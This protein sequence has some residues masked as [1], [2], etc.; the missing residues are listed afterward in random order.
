MA[1]MYPSEW[2]DKNGSAA[3]R[4]IW[5]RLRDQTPDDWFAIHSVGLATHDRKPWAEA[6]FVVVAGE[7]VVVL[8]VK[9]GRVTVEGGRWWTN[10]KPLRES[11]FAQAGGAS[12][13]LYG[14]LKDRFPAI[15][16]AIVGWGVV[17]PD[18]TFD[19]E[20]PDIIPAV[21]YD[22]R[23][24]SAPISDYVKRVGAHW[25]SFHRGRDDAFRPLSRAD[26][27]AIVRYLAPTFDLVPTLRAQMAR[28]EQELARLTA[29]QLRVMRGLR[30]KPRVIIRGGAGTGKTMLAVEE[31]RYLAATG[32]RSLFCCRSPLL[33]EL[34]RPEVE[35]AQVIA[36]DEL[37]RDVVDRADAWDDIPAASA[38]D[39]RDVFLPEVA[40]AALID[41]G[42]DGSI[43]ALVID[44][45]Q[46]LLTEAHLDFFDTILDGGL[47]GGLWRVFLD[48][49][50]NVFSTVDLEQLRRLESC[51]VSDYDLI[52]NCRNTPEVATLTYMLA[53][54][55]PD[56]VLADGGPEVDLRFI[57]DRREISTTVGSIL[58]GWFR[59]GLP[60][61]DVVV[62]GG[63]ELAPPTLSAELARSGV[64]LVPFAERTSRDVAWCSIDEFKGLES[65]A[66][67]VTG[68]TDLRSREGRR[69][70]Y[71]ACSRPRA[72]LGLVLDIDLKEDF[73]VRA[74]EFARLQASGA[75]A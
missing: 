48:H 5:H 3:E 73:D 10:D 41:L 22:D 11:P 33:A 6:D 31:L 29:Q 49:R 57:A 70:I 26:R 56:D 43:G 30:T 12:A 44:E 54:V 38:K 24:L 17:L 18:V 2:S 14:D 25:R 72:L 40:S 8:E 15:R 45:A 64:S 27:S 21:V 69:R 66:V 1:V 7:G 60:P 50:Q 55:D 32:R 16:R 46:D 75:V 67:I 9:G 52:E 65:P 53:A 34:V 35:G 71:V 37:M 23:D 59:R 68:I 74:A 13:A 42:Q 20:G 62:V 36:I 4:L 58:A 19:R 39:I 47:H 63:E 61:G 28:A 51:A